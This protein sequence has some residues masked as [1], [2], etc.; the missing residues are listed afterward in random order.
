[1]CSRSWLLGNL[2]TLHL[3]NHKKITMLKSIL[4]IKGSKT[5][6]KVEQQ[7][8]TGGNSCD[9]Y[10]GPHCY[11]PIKG[12]ASCADYHALPAYHQQCVLVSVECF[13]Q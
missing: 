3:Y 2:A 4:Q 7:R 6:S 13:G 9:T 11:G 1:M 8:V 10:N 5:L 12:C